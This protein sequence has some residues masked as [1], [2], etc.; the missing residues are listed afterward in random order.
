MPDVFVIVAQYP[1]K[2]GETYPIMYAWA[3]STAFATKTGA[4]GAIASDVMSGQSSDPTSVTL[5]NPTTDVGH[6]HNATETTVDVGK[7]FYLESG[8]KYLWF[9]IGGLT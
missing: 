4:T 2:C 1:K 5:D 9:A 7:T 8:K 3:F 6:P